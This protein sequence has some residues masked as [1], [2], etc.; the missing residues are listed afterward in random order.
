MKPFLTSFEQHL[1][2]ELTFSSPESLYQALHYLMRQGGKRIR[3]LLLLMATSIY[4]EQFQR[5]LHAALAIELFHNFTLAHDDIM[6]QAELRR[7]QLSLYKKYGTA[8]GILA[9]DL[10]LIYAYQYLV[11]ELN[12]TLALHI[13]NIFNQA[14]IDVCR[15]QQLDMDFEKRK[16]I[17]MNEY[18]QMITWKTAVLPAAALQIGALIGG[19]PEKE[20][21][22]LHAFGIQLGL[23]FQLQDDWLDTFGSPQQTGKRIGGDILQQKKTALVVAALEATQPHTQQILQALEA[24]QLS[25]EEKIQTVKKQFKNT[26]AQKRVAQMQQTYTQKA[27]EKL[28]QLPVPTSRKEPL[29]NLAFQLLNRKK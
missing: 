29:K 25:E 26:G 3:P 8:S 14:A 28:E 27:L 15:G 19:A 12:P 5:G 18:L 21:Q 17:S 1:A 9:G 11:K 22:I 10:A 16:T 2:R 13:T 6:D 7:G 20:A 24:Q 4:D 23:A